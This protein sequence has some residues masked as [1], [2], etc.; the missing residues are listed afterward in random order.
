MTSGLHETIT[1]ENLDHEPTVVSLE[2]HVDA[3]FADLFAVKE[4]G[5]A[6]RRRGTVLEGELAVQEWGERVRGLRVRASGDPDAGPGT[7]E[8]AVVVPAG[9]QW[10]TEVPRPHRARQHGDGPV[11]SRRAREVQCPG[12]Q[13]GGRGAMPRPP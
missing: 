3:D 7:A 13:D 9:Q 5:A 2:L 10:H 11:S 8:L 4:A 1:V 12:P 6:A